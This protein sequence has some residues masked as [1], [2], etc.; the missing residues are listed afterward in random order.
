MAGFILPVGV[1]IMYYGNASTRTTSFLVFFGLLN[2]G[3]VIYALTG[4]ND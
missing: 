2:L 4:D 3:L 1:A